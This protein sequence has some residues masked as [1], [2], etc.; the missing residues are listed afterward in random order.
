MLY[1]KKIEMAFLWAST[2]IVSGGKC[3]V[4]WDV[5]CRPK[6]LGGLG[7]LNTEFFARALRLRWLWQEWK[8]PMKIWVGLG[9]PCNDTDMDLVYA[10]TTI[11]L[12]NGEK[13]L[14]WMAHWINGCKPLDIAPLIYNISIRKKRM[15]RRPCTTMLGSPKSIRKWRSPLSISVNTFPFGSTL[16]MLLSKKTLMMRS[17]GTSP[18]MANTLLNRPI[19][20]NFFGATSSPIGLFGLEDLDTS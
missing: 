2:D 9:N 1:M 14:F 19:E 6:D 3:M 15:S 7:V 20:L 17:L 12:G 8:E 4:N 10:S 13:N 5:V 16:R 18:K 11:S